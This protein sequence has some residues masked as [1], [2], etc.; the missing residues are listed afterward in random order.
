MW[1]GIAKVVHKG[2]LGDDN[3]D[4]TFWALLVLDPDAAAGYAAAGATCQCSLG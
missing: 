3:G 4:L 1:L 2:R